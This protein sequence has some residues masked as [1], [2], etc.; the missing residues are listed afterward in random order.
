[1]SDRSLY[2][3]LRGAAARAGLSYGQGVRGGFRLY[4]NR[5]TAA[6][7][8]LHSHADMGSVADVLGHSKKTML[9]I[10][11]HSTAE[12]RRRAVEKLQ[13]FHAEDDKKSSAASG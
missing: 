12:S 6:T 8:M 9:E 1:M 13:G 11:D 2:V 3:A 4:D 5:H 10:Y 7:R